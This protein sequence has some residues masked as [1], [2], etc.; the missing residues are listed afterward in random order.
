MNEKL[1]IVASN[2]DMTIGKSNCFNTFE[3]YMDGVER[4]KV[5][6]VECG[7]AASY[8]V[9]VLVNADDV[10]GGP[11][12]NALMPGT[13]WQKIRDRGETP[14]ARGIAIREGIQKTLN[15]FDR[16][17]GVKLQNTNGVAVVV[18]DHGVAEV[19]QV[20]ITPKI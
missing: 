5:R 1:R 13:D 6:L 11:I 2:S 19:F 9:I 10:H 17:A 18:V 12:A 3:R 20:G 8:A 14:F 4:C 15:T 7:L 16:E